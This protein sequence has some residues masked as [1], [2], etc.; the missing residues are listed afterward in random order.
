MPN[1]EEHIQ[2]ANSNIKFF[3]LINEKSQEFFDWKVT[4]AF[5]TAVH[6]INAHLAKLLTSI[7]N[8]IVM[9]N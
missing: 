9:L 3:N 6:I 1:F 7:T 5:Y 8:V 4:A 2:Q